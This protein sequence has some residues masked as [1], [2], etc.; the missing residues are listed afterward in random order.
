VHGKSRLDRELL[1]AGQMAG[2][3]VPP[4][5]ESAFLAEHCRRTGIA[6]FCALEPARSRCYTVSFW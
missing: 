5:S 2:H 1:D 3:L 4:D 6:W